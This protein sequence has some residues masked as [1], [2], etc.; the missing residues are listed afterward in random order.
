M[1]KSRLQKIL[2]TDLESKYL[3]QMGAMIAATTASLGFGL[4]YY[5]RLQS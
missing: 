4:I 3:I 1:E 5:L 2:D